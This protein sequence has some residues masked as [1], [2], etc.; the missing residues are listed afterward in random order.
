MPP[1]ANQLS[2]NIGNGAESGY[3]LGEILDQEEKKEQQ[4]KVE[5]S[6][7]QIMQPNVALLFGI[8]S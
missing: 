1:T 2:L 7:N 6:M 8:S 4:M 5:T 3:V